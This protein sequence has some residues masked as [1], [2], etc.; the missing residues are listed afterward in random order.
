MTPEMKLVEKI[1]YDF[2][3]ATKDSLM[4]YGVIVRTLVFDELV[5]VFI[6]KNPNC[7]VVNIAYSLLLH[8]TA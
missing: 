7:T 6:D 5:K 4:S 3:A 8:S 1:D 2:T